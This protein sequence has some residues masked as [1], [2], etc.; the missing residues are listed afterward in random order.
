MTVS[1]LHR[2]VT[3][4]GDLEHFKGHSSVEKIKLQIAVPSQAVHQQSSSFVRLLH[5]CRCSVSSNFEITQS[6]VNDISC[7][8]KT[9]N[10]G[11][12]SDL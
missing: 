6:E 8:G 4:V 7:F 9:L 2:A 1:E 5:T 12:F 10:V 11:V 3:S